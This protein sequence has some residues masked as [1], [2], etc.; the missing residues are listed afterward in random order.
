MSGWLLI[1]DGWTD[2]RLTRDGEFRTWDGHPV[3][4]GRPV[5][6]HPADK[7]GMGPWWECEM[8][9]PTMPELTE[10]VEVVPA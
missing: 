1:G 4:A 9:L 7:L 10:W 2:T 6:E 3:P 8:P 5:E